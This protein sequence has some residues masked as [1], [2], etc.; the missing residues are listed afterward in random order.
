MDDDRSTSSGRSLARL[1]ARELRRAEAE[2]PARAEGERD[3]HLALL[4]ASVREQRSLAS[5]RRWAVGAAAIAATLLAA[6]GLRGVLLRDRGVAP[7]RA[8]LST[9]Y[10]VHVDGAGP[11]D[12]H[13][14]VAAVPGAPERLRAGDHV[15]SRTGL[16][17]V[18][19]ATGT[20]LTLDQ[21]ADLAV[22]EEG[23]AQVFAL[24]AGNVRADVAKLHEG[25]RFLVRTADTEVEVRGTSFRVERVDVTPECHPD[26]HTRVIVSEGVVVVRHAGAEDRVK[27]GE[28]WPAPCAPTPAPAESSTGQLVG[29]A[30][31][32]PASAP[33]SPALTAPSASSP[34]LLPSGVSPLP[35]AAPA[36]AASVSKLA[37]SNELFASAQAARRGGDPRA[38]VGLFEKL[39]AEY[40]ASPIVESAIVERMRTLGPIDR[41]AS[42][43][44][45]RDYLAR[46]PRGFARGEAE[47][48]VALGP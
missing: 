12:I 39:I 37:A 5:R 38:A 25:E 45:A 11:D 1:A 17:A 19:V 30:P 41:A 29:V 21:G 4:A 3:A 35:S 16:V 26:L 15:T 36:R 44:A 32:R 9:P 28:Q 34:A 6:V 47:A 10:D 22:V 46:F 13:H 23:N 7:S 27:A 40:P 48:I 8:A 43:A 20:R 18:V 2:V 33:A 31:A 14:G 24:R 42:V